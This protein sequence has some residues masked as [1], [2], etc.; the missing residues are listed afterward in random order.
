MRSA[1][2]SHLPRT[3]YDMQRQLQRTRKISLSLN[4]AHTLTD[5]GFNSHALKD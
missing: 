5:W 2:Y 1:E 4:N 3:S